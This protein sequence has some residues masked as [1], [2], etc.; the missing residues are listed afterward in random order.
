MAYDPLAIT[1]HSLAAV[2]VML[3]LVILWQSLSESP[4][5]RAMREARAGSER[6]DNPGVINP[7]ASVNIDRLNSNAENGDVDAQYR[8][9][10]ALLREFDI[11]TDPATQSEAIAMLRKAADGDHSQAQSLMGDLYFQG[12]GVVQDFVQAFDW[13]SKAANQGHAEAMYGLGKM[14]RSGWGRPV[15]LV[16]AYVWLNLASARGESRAVQARQ[17]VLLQLSSG[18]LA[19]AQQKSREL[20]LSIP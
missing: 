18:E 10:M 3:F 19:E 20:D 13:Y 5:E 17:E 11:S 15:S 1:F 8:L 16:D 6:S 12:R 14:S 9:G 7:R 2:A 4:G